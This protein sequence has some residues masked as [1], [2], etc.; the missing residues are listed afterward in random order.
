MK[1]PDPWE[2]KK[3]NA[4]RKELRHKRENY[5]KRRR[6]EYNQ[7]QHVEDKIGPEKAERRKEATKTIVRR[8]KEK[9]EDA[10][11]QSRDAERMTHYDANNTDW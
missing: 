1:N 6:L 5:F 11:N 9:N 7:N 10:T 8:W 4:E 3:Q 2:E